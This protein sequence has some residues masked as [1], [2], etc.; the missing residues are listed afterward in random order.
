[1]NNAKSTQSILEKE[2]IHIMNS[3][4]SLNE[5]KNLSDSSLKKSFNTSSEIIATTNSK[6]EIVPK[7]PDKLNIVMNMNKKLT[8]EIEATFKNRENYSTESMETIKLEDDCIKEPILDDS[9]KDNTGSPFYADPVDALKEVSVE[10]EIKNTDNVLSLRCEINTS[11]FMF[12]AGLPQVQRRKLIR[13]GMNLSQRYSEP[14]QNH[15]Y[16]PLR[17]MHSI[18]ELSRKLNILAK[19]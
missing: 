6:G 16:Y 5:K 1:M 4:E 10:I 11:L 2:N 3:T 19:L 14:P 17:D 12:K 18:E 9:D 15:P 8:E 13:V 7:R